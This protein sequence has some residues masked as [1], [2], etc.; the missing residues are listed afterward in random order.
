MLTEITLILLPQTISIVMH[1]KY[2]PIL[3][4]RETKKLIGK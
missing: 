2:K 1:G 3:L 4:A